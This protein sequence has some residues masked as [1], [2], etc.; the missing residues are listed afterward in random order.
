MP[1]LCDWA[2]TAFRDIFPPEATPQQPAF[3]GL[4][5][6]R[7]QGTPGQTG[8]RVLTIPAAFFIAAVVYMLLRLA[9][10]Q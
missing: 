1:A 3:D 10:A 2:N 9:G 5:P 6:T 8:V 7:E 4:D